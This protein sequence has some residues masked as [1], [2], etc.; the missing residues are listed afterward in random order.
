MKKL[1]LAMVMMFTLCAC[2]TEKDVNSAGITEEYELI[3]DTMT[4]TNTITYE[5]DEVLKQT[6]VSVI[7]MEALGITEKD[8]ATEID[9]FKEKYNID[10][11]QYEPV[12]K[13]TTL[14]E[15][16]I[17]DFE[18]ANLSELVDAGIITLPEGAKTASFIS[19]KETVKGLEE[20]G[21][22]KK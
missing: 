6:I 1:M 19:Y 15:T 10:G 12:F 21:F 9:G 16:T 17:I 14:T 18:K 5:D 11:V 2:G 7:N 22:T 8:V 20:M 3:Q 13:D 4:V